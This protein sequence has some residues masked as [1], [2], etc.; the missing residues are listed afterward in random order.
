[1]A[2]VRAVILT[3]GEENY[4][5]GL[6]HSLHA[7]WT[8][9]HNTPKELEALRRRGAGEKK[10]GEAHGL[11]PS[12]L[13]IGYTRDKAANWLVNASYPLTP[14]EEGRVRGLG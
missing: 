12:N 4:L 9:G 10:I 2:L 1:V 6:L 13:S 14:E 7:E 5:L 11:D 3:Q 8:E